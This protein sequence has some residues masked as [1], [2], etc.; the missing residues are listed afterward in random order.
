MAQGINLDD[1]PNELLISILVSLEIPDLMQ[2]ASTNCR[3]RQLCSDSRFWRDKFRHDGLTLD[4]PE[5]FEEWVRHYQ[6]VKQEYKRAQN[7]LQKIEYEPY[8]NKPSGIFMNDLNDYPYLLQ[9]PLRF[10]NG[11][12]TSLI[13]QTL[14]ES[15]HDSTNRIYLYLDK[16]YSNPDQFQWF[17]RSDSYT[18]VSLGPRLIGQWPLTPPQILTILYYFLKHKA[19]LRDN[20]HY[21]LL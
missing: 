11:I 21:K 4:I 14:I 9:V 3:I 20:I 17:L 2:I 10:L 8:Y 19:T 1:L 5:T 12:N 7:I 13:R 6:Q 18:D 16:V 15:K